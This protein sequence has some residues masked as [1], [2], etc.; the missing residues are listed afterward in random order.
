MDRV[1]ERSRITIQVSFDNSP[2]LKINM[3]ELYIMTQL[4]RESETSLLY[5]YLEKLF[6]YQSGLGM[7]VDVYEGEE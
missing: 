2:I 1:D 6:P 5:K 7:P 4:E 3:T